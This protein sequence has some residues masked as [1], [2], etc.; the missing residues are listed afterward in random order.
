M[1][2]YQA[3]LPAQWGNTPHKFSFWPR[4]PWRHFLPVDDKWGNIWRET[5]RARWLSSVASRVKNHFNQRGQNRQISKQSISQGSRV[6]IFF[7]KEHESGIFHLGLSGVEKWG[8]VTVRLC[9][10]NPLFLLVYTKLA[11]K[12]SN[13]SVNSCLPRPLHS[14]CSYQMHL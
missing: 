13:F 12:L 7:Q 6:S 5:W 11:A 8:V 14:F 9:T 2:I 1:E 3:W 4:L 10:F